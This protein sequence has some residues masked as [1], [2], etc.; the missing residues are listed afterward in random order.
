LY[1]SLVLTRILISPC[2]YGLYNEILVDKS[3]GLL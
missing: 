3:V 1:V 2:D